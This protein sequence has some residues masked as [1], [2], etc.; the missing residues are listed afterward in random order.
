MAT[1]FKGNVIGNLRTREGKKAV[2]EL[3]AVL[4]KQKPT[5]QLKWNENLMK[6]ARDWAAV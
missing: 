2:D 6:A 3:V 5:T 1:K 4:K